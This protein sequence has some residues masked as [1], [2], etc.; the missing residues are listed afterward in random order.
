MKDKNQVKLTPEQLQALKY[1]GGVIVKTQEEAD[2]IQALTL[3]GTRRSAKMPE[4]QTNALRTHLATVERTSRCLVNSPPKPVCST[5]N[6]IRTGTLSRQ[7]EGQGYD[8]FC[9][10]CCKLVNTVKL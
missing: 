5:C 10:D 6:G 2:F 3:G 9:Y 7:Q 8:V 1:G 4:Q